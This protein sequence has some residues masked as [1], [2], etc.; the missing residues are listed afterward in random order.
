L[1]VLIKEGGA[2]AGDVRFFAGYAGWGSGQL[3]GEMK[4][5]SWYV[6]D[7]PVEPKLE[8]VMN[9]SPGDLWTTMMKS[10]GGGYGRVT[11]W[12]TDPSLN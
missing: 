12:P 3:E 10:K 2:K 1:A 5:R 6:H 7:A 8:V 9:P 11:T 4:Q